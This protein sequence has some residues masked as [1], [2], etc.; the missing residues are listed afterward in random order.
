M[1]ENILVVHSIF[2]WIL[3][4]VAVVVIVKA[5][6]GWLMKKPFTKMDEKGG[7]ILTI[8][9]DIQLLLGLALYVFLSPVTKDAF[10]DFGAAM[11]NSELRYYAVEHIAVMIIAIV[12]FHIGK[13][14]VKKATTDVK[15]HFTAA[16]FYGIGLVLIL[17]RIP[18]DSTSLFKWF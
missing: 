4:L 17:S 9:A 3:L 11:K 2:R 8:V 6:W 1:Y 13:S 15:K 16:L 18:W 7:L 5:K 14:R 12:L 10:Q